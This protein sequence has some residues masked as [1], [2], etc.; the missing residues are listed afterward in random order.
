LPSLAEHTFVLTLLTKKDCNKDFLC[1]TPEHAQAFDAIKALVLGRDCLTSIDY[2]NPELRKIFVTCNVSKRR[3]GSMLSFRETWETARPVA[4][5][6][7]QL[8][9]AKLHYSV[10][11]QEMLS[12]MHALAK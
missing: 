4:F 3:M 8:K 11:K 6:S 7:R 2:Q 10:H 12:I 5:E 9:G 1:W